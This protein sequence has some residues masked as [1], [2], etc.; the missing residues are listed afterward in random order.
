M[1]SRA[2]GRQTK[3]GYLCFGDSLKYSSDGKFAY[4]KAL[5]LYYEYDEFFK[6]KNISKDGGNC[7]S[8]Q[9]FYKSIEFYD[10]MKPRSIHKTNY[11]IINL[12][13]IKKWYQTQEDIS[14][15]IQA[16]EEELNDV[17]IPTEI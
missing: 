14:S 11:F 13:E 4:F 9:S 8:N 16:T 2:T 5:T 1:E 17:F 12:D 10:F 6:T 3:N 15:F 7:G